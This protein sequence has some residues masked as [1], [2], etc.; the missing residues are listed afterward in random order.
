VSII[1][2]RGAQFTAQFWKSFQ[3]GLNSKVN[4]S[5]AFHPQ[6]YG[7][8]EH[9]I[10]TLEDMLRECVI[11]FKGNW[12]DRLPL[13]EFTYNNSY[14]FSIQMTPY[15]SLYGRRCRSPIGWFGVLKAELIGPDLV[16][17]AMEKM[18]II[19]ERL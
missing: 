5:N 1:S 12:D 7:Q 3:K 18:K 4:L 2:D 14:Q 10:L 13:I 8:V 6:T 19:Q 17:Q 16:N 9:T 11:D 15:E